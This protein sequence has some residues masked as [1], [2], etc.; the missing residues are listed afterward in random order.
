V[1]G[2]GLGHLYALT[3]DGGTAAATVALTT[4]ATGLGISNNTGPNKT[5]YSS[6]NTGSFFA[7]SNDGTSGT[8]VEKSDASNV[9][10]TRKAWLRLE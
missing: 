7:S 5:I 8:A 10:A 1:G 4:G 9:G 2:A 6:T 3:T